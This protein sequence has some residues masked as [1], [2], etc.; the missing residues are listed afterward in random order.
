MSS[1]LVE[2]GEAR[3]IVCA[4]GEHTQAGKAERTL[5]IEDEMTPLQ[6]K[7]ETIAE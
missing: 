6:K 2:T 5:D 1:T 3:A 7:L 4:V